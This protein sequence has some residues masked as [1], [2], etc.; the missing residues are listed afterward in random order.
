MACEGRGETEA[1]GRNP[2]FSTL[3]YAIMNLLRCGSGKRKKNEKKSNFRNFNEGRVFWEGQF[4]FSKNIKYGLWL[5]LRTHALSVVC[6]VGRAS[7]QARQ[8]PFLMLM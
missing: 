3:D 8:V 5:V 6:Y 7:K 1:R 2:L 4:L